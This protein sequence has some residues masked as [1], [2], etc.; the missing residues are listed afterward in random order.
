MEEA[1]RFRDYIERV[2]QLIKTPIKLNTLIVPRINSLA[3]TSQIFADAEL[4][5]DGKWQT[6]RLDREVR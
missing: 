2:D 3:I 1:P 5:V 4:N 6:C